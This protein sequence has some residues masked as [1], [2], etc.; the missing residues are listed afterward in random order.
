MNHQEEIKALQILAEE[1]RFAVNSKILELEMA[2]NQHNATIFQLNKLQ[3]V[4]LESQMNEVQDEI[5][6][7]LQNEVQSEVQTVYVTGPEPKLSILKRNQKATQKK[8]KAQT[9]NKIKPEK[10][11]KTDTTILHLSINNKMCKRERMDWI[12]IAEKIEDETGACTLSK[13]SF[14]VKPSGELLGWV[15][16]KY[17]TPDLAKEAMHHFIDVEKDNLDKKSKF[18]MQ[19]D[20]LKI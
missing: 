20:Y 11:R 12:D 19:V 9:Q 1:Q 5:E 8:N 6:V 2:K 15:R 10:E 4:T 14:G 17:D 18:Y 16:V 7:Q 13:D 3:Q